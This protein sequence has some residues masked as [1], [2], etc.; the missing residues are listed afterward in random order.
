MIAMP[1]SGCSPNSSWV[2]RISGNSLETVVDERRGVAVVGEQRRRQQQLEQRGRHGEGQVRRDQGV[3]AVLDPLGDR[4]R[5]DRPVDRRDEIAQ[6][7][8]GDD[9]EEHQA[10]TANVEDHRDQCAE[11][12][13]VEAARRQQRRSGADPVVPPDEHGDSSQVRE[14]GQQLIGVDEE[15]RCRPDDGDDRERSHAPD[16]ASHDA[17]QQHQPH[18]EH[19]DLDQLQPVVVVAP[20]VDERRQQQRPTPRV[21]QRAEGGIGVE[22][23]EAVVGEHRADVAVEQAA[24]LA[25]VQREVVTLG[26]AVAMQ[27]DRQR[28]CAQ[29]D[30]RERDGAQPSGRGQRD[31]AHRV[32]ICAS[33]FRLRRQ[34]SR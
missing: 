24:G 3:P 15:H 22:D 18:A 17:V 5:P 27:L 14:L 4:A 2:D 23:G 1:T 29:H 10:L 30:D 11:D 9:P 8:D 7:H 32:T 19:G 13:E 26:V 31:G 16:P 28:R 34:V 20:Q 6:L 21:G 12:D 25:Q 33:P